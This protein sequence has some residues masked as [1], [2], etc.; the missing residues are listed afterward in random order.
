MKLRTLN[1]AAEE[2]GTNRTRLRNGVI[3]GRYPYLKWGNRYLVDVD[4]LAGI[5][6][7]EEEAKGR[8]MVGLRA[9]A[10]EIGVQPSAL[11]RMAEAGF[12]PCRT[13]GGRYRF[14]VRDVK[15]ALEERMNQEKKEE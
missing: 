2:L 15:K 10:A 9:C 13:A 3:E 6:E 1:E 8:D 7:R 5:L 11:R 4:R 12:V 14:R